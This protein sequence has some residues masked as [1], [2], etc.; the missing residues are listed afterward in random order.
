[1]IDLGPHPYRPDF[2]GHAPNPKHWRR[3]TFFLSCGILL[4]YY[5]CCKLEFYHG[6]FLEPPIRPFPLQGYFRNVYLDDPNYDD[7]KKLMKEDFAKLKA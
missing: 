4:I 1:D 7:K 3:N 2:A 5:Q 6:R